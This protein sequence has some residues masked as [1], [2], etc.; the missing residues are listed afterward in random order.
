MWPHNL[1]TVSILTLVIYGCGDPL[2]KADYQGEPMLSLEG[3]IDLP[4]GPNFIALA[5][6]ESDW[7]E[8]QETCSDCDPCDDTFNECADEMLIAQPEPPPLRLGIFWSREVKNGA[9][10]RLQAFSLVTSSFPARWSLTLYS[11][12]PNAALLR[13][14]DSG[15][16]SLGLVLVWLDA[17][18]DGRWTRGSDPIVGGAE[19]RAVLYTPDGVNDERL[20]HYGPGYHPLS[21]FPT[22]EIGLGHEGERD[23]SPMTLE[24]SLE[25]ELLR[26][27]VLDTNC[28]GTL[29][30][31]DICPAQEEIEA[32]CEGADLT[33]CDLCLDELS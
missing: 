2:A 10:P 26:N 25:P 3:P 1:V 20:G 33:L 12:P 6:C 21:L 5:S 28:D 30:E 29:D 8:C 23:D 9:E 31:F 22:C 17:N 11:P 14:S 24:L 18:E 19:L 13:G 7:F 16:Y 4:N 32:A 15:R 27:L